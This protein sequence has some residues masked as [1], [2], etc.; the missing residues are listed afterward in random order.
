MRDPALFSPEKVWASKECELL[1]HV[2]PILHITSGDDTRQYSTRTK[3]KGVV[4]P[5]PSHRR[6]QMCTGDMK[7]SHGCAN[8]KETTLCFFF[9]FL[10]T[11]KIV[12]VEKQNIHET[13]IVRSK[14]KP[15]YH[16]MNEIK[17]STYRITKCAK[18]KWHTKSK[19][20]V[21]TSIGVTNVIRTQESRFLSKTNSLYSVS[22]IKWLMSAYMLLMTP[23]QR[24]RMRR[25]SFVF[26]KKTWKIWLQS[27]MT[28]KLTAKHVAFLAC[29]GADARVQACRGRSAVCLPG[30]EV[31]VATF[32]VWEAWVLSH[33]NRP[34]PQSQAL[35]VKL[36][37]RELVNGWT[38][39][40]WRKSKP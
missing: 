4:V 39:I 37:G 22:M 18:Y 40:W 3:P 26:S 13:S 7:L 21:Y 6:M 16:N 32:E 15:T 31:E 17:H 27:W 11:L 24:L 12:K 36:W 2:S 10:K 1:Q 14:T 33:C 5:P 25:Q 28:Q 23:R 19:T 8:A 34:E 30:A 38:K 29:C 35:D 20:H 9:Q